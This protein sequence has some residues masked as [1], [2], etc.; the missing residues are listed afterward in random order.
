MIQRYP[1]PASGLTAEDMTAL[2]Q[3]REALSPKIPITRLIVQAVRAMYMNVSTT[4]CTQT[5]NP[6]QEEAA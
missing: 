6:E 4:P 2:H 1:W 3:A 5:P